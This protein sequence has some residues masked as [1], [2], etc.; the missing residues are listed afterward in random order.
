MF[1]KRSLLVWGVILGLSGRAILARCCSAF[2]KQRWPRALPDAS[3]FSS[4][5]MGLGSRFGCVCV[6]CLCGRF[7]IRGLSGYS[8]SECT[9]TI[10]DP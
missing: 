4:R 7:T 9:A 2:S 5:V 8:W 10:N 1:R 6:C 3:G